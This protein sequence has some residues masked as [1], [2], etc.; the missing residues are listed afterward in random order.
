[1][2]YVMH[3]LWMHSTES[4]EQRLYRRI[5]GYAAVALRITA[6]TID[7]DLN[8][9]TKSSQELLTFLITGRVVSFT[10]LILLQ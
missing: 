10:I 3:Q 1:M 8:A 5:I 9:A 2:L 7:E 4:H 6:H